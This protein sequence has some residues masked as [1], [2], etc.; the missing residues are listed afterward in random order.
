VKENKSP[1]DESDQFLND[2][3]ANQLPKC[4]CGR[5]PS[6]EM[7]AKSEEIEELEKEAVQMV[8]DNIT[9]ETVAEL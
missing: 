5:P 6:I 4:N 8:S 1:L 2:S 9:E 3:V 7:V